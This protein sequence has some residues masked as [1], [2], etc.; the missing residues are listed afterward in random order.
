MLSDCLTSHAASQPIELNS[1]RFQ[2]VGVVRRQ[3]GRIETTGPQ[4]TT[5]TSSKSQRLSSTSTAQFLSS[6]TWDIG[7]RGISSANEPP[8]E[9]FAIE[10]NLPALNISPTR[11]CLMRGGSLYYL[12]SIGDVQRWLA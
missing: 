5:S 6:T 11:H 9:M 3:W 4:A 2:G 8:L 1:C 10:N 12:L 7:K